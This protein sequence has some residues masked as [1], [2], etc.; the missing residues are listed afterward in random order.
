MSE[1]DRIGEGILRATYDLL[2]E[3][4]VQAL[5]VEAVAERAGVAK[6]TVYRR[7]RNRADLST[8][9]LARFDDELDGVVLPDG[10]RLQLRTF[11]V[12]F[13]TTFE[14]V[15]LDVLGT[16]L[17]E[18]ADSELLELHRARVVV[19]HRERMSALVRAAQERGEVRPDFDGRLA[20]EMLVGSFFARHVGGR[21]LDPEQWADESVDLL[22]RGM[23]VDGRPG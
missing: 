22:W 10:L 7:F 3:R 20:M 8:A 5:T 14:R 4:G 6:T 18:P 19:P 1:R 17:S 9:A 21:Q 16:M 11:L 12:A 13:A 15:G 23:A 2:V